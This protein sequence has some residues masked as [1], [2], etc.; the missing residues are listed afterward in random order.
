MVKKE[1]TPEE[2]AKMNRERFLQW[3]RD[4]DVQVKE[5]N[6]EIN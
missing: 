5:N 3:L 6:N 4:R 1:L 2:I